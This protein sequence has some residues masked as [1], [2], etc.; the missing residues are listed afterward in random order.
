MR[1]PG[2][3]AAR[4]RRPAP[5]SGCT[6]DRLRPSVEAAAKAAILVEALPYIRRFWG[7]VVV[8]KYGGN[9]LA[10]AASGRRRR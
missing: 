8:V 1:Q 7:Q 5:W 6:R 2:P 9:A 4:D 3:G 10:G